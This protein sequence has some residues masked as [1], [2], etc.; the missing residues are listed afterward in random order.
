MSQ[1]AEQHSKNSVE[2][3]KSRQRGNWLILLALFVF[4]AF[5]VT[6]TMLK[7]DV[8]QFMSLTYEH[9][10]RQ[11]QLEAQRELQKNLDAAASSSD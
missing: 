11:Q 8:S 10:G 2:Y 6:V 7:F 9:E 4:V 5:T 3:L 1:Q